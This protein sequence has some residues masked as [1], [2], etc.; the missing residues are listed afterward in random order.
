MEPDKLSDDEMDRLLEE[1]IRVEEPD[2]ERRALAASI[3]A[4]NHIEPLRREALVPARRRSRARLVVL[5]LGW[6]G[7]GIAVLL[8]GEIAELL[9]GA[10]LEPALGSP[11]L[12]KAAAWFSVPPFVF[13]VGM[14]SLIVVSAVSLRFALA[15][16]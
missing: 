2:A 1:S 5:L 7:A 10:R 8:A 15:D 4:I 6:I 14:V 12:A 9:A 16:E 13:A 11:L 3:R